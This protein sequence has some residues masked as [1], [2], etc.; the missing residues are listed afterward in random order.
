MVSRLC[1]DQ[2]IRARS[3][4]KP[5]AV[6]LR[7]HTERAELL[8]KLSRQVAVPE[9]FFR[10]RQIGICVVSLQAALMKC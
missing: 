9:S 8:A 7:M 5:D 6:E 10:S 1:T 4:R 2:S 3:T